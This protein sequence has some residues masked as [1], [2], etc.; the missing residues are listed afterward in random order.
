MHS[1]GSSNKAQQA[2]RNSKKH[3]Q[4]LSGRILVLITEEKVQKKL[5]GSHLWYVRSVST[6]G[7]GCRENKNK[8]KQ[9]VQTAID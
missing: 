3:F 7:Y 9:F 8:Q 6:G 2:V 1:A 4:N 5:V